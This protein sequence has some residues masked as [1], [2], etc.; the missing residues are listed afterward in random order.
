MNEELYGQYGMLASGCHAM[1]APLF[2][3]LDPES[4][5]VCL[6]DDGGPGRM[7]ARNQRRMGIDN[8]P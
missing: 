8:F 4:N 1:I 3:D 5:R 2:L 7:S 6:M